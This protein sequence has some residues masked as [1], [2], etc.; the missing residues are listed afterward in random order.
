MCSLKAGGDDAGVHAAALF[1]SNFRRFAEP[2][3]RCRIC[4]VFHLGAGKNHALLSHPLMGSGC[5]S[6]RSF[7]E[8]GNPPGKQRVSDQENALGKQ[9]ELEDKNPEIAEF[10]GR[11]LETTVNPFPPN[12]THKTFSVCHFRIPY[13]DFLRYSAVM[14]PPCAAMSF[15]V[16][17]NTI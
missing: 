8:T 10:T 1:P 5:P 4:S 6:P 12:Y 16:P 7:E 15:G 17:A 13:S 3:K 2:S 9:H 14:V 11:P